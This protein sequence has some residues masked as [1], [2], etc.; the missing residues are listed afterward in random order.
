MALWRL[1]YHL[2][3]TTKNRY[4]YLTSDKEVRI[5]PYIISKADTL[6]CIVHAIGGIEDHVHLITSIPPKLSLADFVKNIKGS[7]AHFYNKIF[8]DEARF[9]WQEGY[10]VF[11]LG[12]KQ[13]ETAVNYVNNQKEH[14]RNWRLPQSLYRDISGPALL[15]HQEYH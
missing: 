2:V 15:D 5:Y 9:S 3:W 4:P 7:S 13:L 1:Y 6:G 8:P 14:H 12:G 10:G 11:S